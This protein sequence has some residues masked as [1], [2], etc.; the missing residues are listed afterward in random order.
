MRLSWLESFFCVYQKMIIVVFHIF[1]VVLIEDLSV[2]ICSRDF[3]Y[4]IFRTKATAILKGK[5]RLSEI[6]YLYKCRTIYLL[7]H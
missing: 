2:Y 4:L 5:Y 3:I 7:R 6:V 1:I